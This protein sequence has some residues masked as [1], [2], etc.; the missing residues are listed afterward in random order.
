MR[1]TKSG[2]EAN[3]SAVAPFS[4]SIPAGAASCNGV[5]SRGLLRVLMIEDSEA[6]AFFLEK[7]LQRGG[8]KVRC[9]RVDTAEATIAAL[10][11]CTWDVILADHSMPMFSA[12]EALRILQEHKLDIPFIIVSGHIEEETAVSAM[13]AGAHDYIMKDRLA[14][15]V[16]AVERELREAETRRAQ[17]ECEA[18]LRRAHNELESRVQRRTAALQEANVRL[19]AAFEE[20]RRLENELLEIA[21]N[22]RRNI[23]FDLHDDLGQKLTG[24]LLLTQALEKQLCR[25][26]HSFAADAGR[27]SELVGEVIH[28][29][30]NLAHQFSSI[31]ARSKNL[32]DALK[33]LVTDVHKMFDLPCA[34]EIKGT[35]PA[36][37]NHSV[38]Q[39][40]K[41]AQEAISNAV[42]HGKATRVW[43]SAC[44][45]DGKLTLT[46]RNDG[47]PF[48]LPEEK[49]GRMGLRIMN[50]RANTIGATF[51]IKP[52]QKNGT[53]C[54]CALPLGNG[55]EQPA[56]PE[57]SRSAKPNVSTRP[58][59]RELPAETTVA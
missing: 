50:Y 59:L 23:G 18:E 52:N 38:Q 15:L 1:D 3:T 53:I 48:S 42:K 57:F 12:P 26:N 21:E 2:S 56:Q 58:H 32:C 20:R 40:Y 16:P 25:E 14:R 33:Q 34:L 28:R 36:L 30:H 17:R 9:L 4:N 55:G 19:Q 47:V 29:T 6:D 13:Q 35:V 44:R 31:D 8:W 45:S 22:E 41:I 54:T 49:K 24:I 10:E 43:I 11:D 46:I 7:A 27:I 39:F 37:P 51:D 5:Q